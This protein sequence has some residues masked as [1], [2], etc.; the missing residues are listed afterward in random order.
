[1]LISFRLSAYWCNSKTPL[2]DAYL[3][4]T[5]FIFLMKTNPEKNMTHNAL[6]KFVQLNYIEQACLLLPIL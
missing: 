2:R 5:V 6:K 4:C 1:M 3:K